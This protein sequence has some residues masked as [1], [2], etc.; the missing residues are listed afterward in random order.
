MLLL[1]AGSMA[2]SM[3]VKSAANLKWYGEGYS[4]F[5]TVLATPSSLEVVYI[6]TNNKEV[7]SYALTNP[8]AHTSSTGHKDGSSTSGTGGDN[9]TGYSIEKFSTLAFLIFIILLL[10]CGFC[11]FFCMYRSKQ[12]SGGSNTTTA[13]L[14]AEYGPLQSNSRAVTSPTEDRRRLIPSKEPLVP[15]SPNRHLDSHA[16][17]LPTSPMERR[18]HTIV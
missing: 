12:E 17:L 7:Y 1:G 4:A 9:M 3:S 11:L 10:L 14:P 2:D 5:A 13:T 18:F 8:L 6:N 15:Y 16:R